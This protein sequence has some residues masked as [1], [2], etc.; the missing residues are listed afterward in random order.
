LNFK[1][2]AIGDSLNDL[3]MLE[4]A[5]T[6]ILFKSSNSIKNKYSQYFNCDT[7]SDL[8]KKIHQTFKK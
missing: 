5:D 8:L 2:I 4:V 7:Y 3:G 6:G 1:T